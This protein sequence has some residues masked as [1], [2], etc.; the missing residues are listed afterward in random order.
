M[1]PP[2]GF[3]LSWTTSSPTSTRV[4]VTPWLVTGLPSTTARM[5]SSCARPRTAGMPAL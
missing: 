1:L 5:G 2:P 4:R 3:R